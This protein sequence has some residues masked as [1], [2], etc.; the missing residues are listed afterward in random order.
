MMPL[1]Y[2][3]MMIYRLIPDSDNLHLLSKLLRYVFNEQ[4]SRI[5]PQGKT[6]S[7]AEIKLILTQDEGDSTSQLAIFPWLSDI[8]NSWKPIIRNFDS[9]NEPFGLLLSFPD[10]YS[11]LGMQLQIDEKPIGVLLLVHHL[12]DQYSNESQIIADKFCKYASVG[13]ENAR[14][15]SACT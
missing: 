10:D 2:G 15:Y 12:P 7:I 13:I 4:F 5:N 14:M 6:I 11:A 9:P 3:C 1:Q 8:T